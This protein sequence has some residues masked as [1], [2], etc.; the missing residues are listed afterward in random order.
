[1]SK[2]TWLTMIAVAAVVVIQG[3]SLK[4]QS[5]HLDPPLKVPGAQVA[6]GTLIGLGI[7]DGRTV[8]KLGEVGD[9]NTKMVEVSLT[10]DF[11]PA[12]YKKVSGV[13]KE[14]GYEV[15]PAS[16]AMTR[17]LQISVKRLELTSVKTA[18]NFETE[19]RAELSASA[20]ND[21]ET[22]DRL[23]YVRTYKETATPPYRK[24]S[25]AMVNTAV[26][27][28]LEDILSDEKMLQLLA[29]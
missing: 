7:S 18:F 8:Q 20:R 12:L 27:Q 19:L 25:N 29:R 9:P 16:G 28:A 4:P 23:F 21:N 14:K 6:N 2:K 10:E 5:L 26:S 22:Y 3:C 11:S 15:V 17:S 1:M 13:L 24:D